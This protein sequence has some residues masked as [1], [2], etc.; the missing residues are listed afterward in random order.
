MNELEKCEVDE[1]RKKRWYCVVNE[2]GNVSCM[3]RG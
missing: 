1:K 2:E 3:R